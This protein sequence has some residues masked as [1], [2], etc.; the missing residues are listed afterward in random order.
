MFSVFQ[1][2]FSAQKQERKFKVNSYRKYIS[3]G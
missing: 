2:G 1:D 3:R